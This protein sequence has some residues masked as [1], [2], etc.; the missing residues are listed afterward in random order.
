MTIKDDH[1]ARVRSLVAG[2][3]TT[4]GDPG[5]LA[6]EKPLYELGID[7]LA[8][9]NLIVVL[10]EEAG[11]DLEEYIDDIDT[12]RTI[13]DLCAVAAMFERVKAAC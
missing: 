11:I 5:V 9:V 12:P 1:L 13:G 3:V 6:P 7:S 8:T 4:I 10:A 2:I